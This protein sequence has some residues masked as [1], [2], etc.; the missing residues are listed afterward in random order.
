MNRSRHAPRPARWPYLLSALLLIAPAYYFYQSLHPVFPE[1]WSE[2]HIGPFTAT[3]APVEN[4][5]AYR[6]D[7]AYIRDFQV[8]FCEACHER[9]RLARL[10]VGPAPGVPSAEA[11][12]IVHGPRG[13]QGAHVRFPHWPPDTEDRLWLIVQ[14]WSGETHVTAWPLY[15]G[16]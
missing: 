3:V 13:A 15:G 7:G 2:R 6:Y 10:H 16:F 11:A 9:I 14:E 1:A 12:G 5:S 4:G 8:R